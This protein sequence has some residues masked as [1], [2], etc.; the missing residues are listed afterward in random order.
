MDDGAAAEREMMPGD[1][2]PLSPSSRAVE[3]I[4]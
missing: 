3:W 4:R 2:I 1:Q